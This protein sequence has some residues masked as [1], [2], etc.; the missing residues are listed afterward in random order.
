M[1][2]FI[3]TKT[4]QYT[5]EVEVEADTAEAAIDAAMDMDGTRIHDDMLTDSV[6][7]RAAD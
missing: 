4:L 3:V 2:K 6:A 1:P 5:E 7:R